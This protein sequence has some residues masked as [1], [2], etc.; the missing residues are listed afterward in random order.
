[1][2][3]KRFFT[4]LAL[5]AT[6][7]MAR[8]VFTATVRPDPEQLARVVQ[9]IE[10]LDALRSGLAGTFESQGMP[11]DQTT[12]QQVCKPVGMKAKSSAQENGWKIIQMA[13]KNRNPAHKLDARGQQVFQMMTEDK[14]LMGVWMRAEI[15]GKSGWR[16]FRR[17]TVEAACLACHGPKENRPEF[18]KQ[19]YPEDRAYDF[20]VG[21]LRGFYSVFVPDQK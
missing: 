7:L 11:A 8:S 10:G 13:E 18:V 15:D 21:D 1:M 16:Y 5:L 17:I 6:L 2:R 4:M 3:H 14:E 20:R 9:E 12:F 19:N